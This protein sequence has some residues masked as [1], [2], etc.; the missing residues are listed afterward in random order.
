MSARVRT[1]WNPSLNGQK[2]DGPGGCGHALS[3]H[4][5]LGYC[6]QESKRDGHCLCGESG[7]AKLA[8]GE[9]TIVLS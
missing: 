1:D 3:H 5:T 4:N 9:T 6:R 8:R 2:C 7:H